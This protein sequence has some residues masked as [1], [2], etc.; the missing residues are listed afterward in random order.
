MKMQPK[1]KFYS[2]RVLN[3]RFHCS[4]GAFENP[5]VLFVCLCNSVVYFRYY[6]LN[7]FNHLLKQEPLVLFHYV[8]DDGIRNFLIIACVILR[9][10]FI[11]V[12]DNLSDRNP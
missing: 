11:G 8:G 3:D 7:M 5:F 12:I 10:T 1:G 6:E 4:S 2:N 9:F